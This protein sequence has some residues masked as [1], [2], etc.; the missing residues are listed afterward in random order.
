MEKR[1]YLRVPFKVTAAV[2]GRQGSISGMVENLSMKG[3]FFATGE[4]LSCDGPFEIT[5]YLSGSSSMLSLKLKGEIVRQTK[6]GVAIEFKEMDLDSFTHLRNIIEQNSDDAD[7][8]YKE[9]CRS[10]MPH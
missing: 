8:V 3:M 10:L 1:K 6:T 2:E 5:I 9:Y 7:A 4:T